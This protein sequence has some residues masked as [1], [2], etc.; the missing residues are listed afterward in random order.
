MG[1]KHVI[2]RKVE[3]MLIIF[4]FIK[5]AIPWKRDTSNK[6]QISFK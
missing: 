1:I 6:I 3:D 2:A 4:D 5:K